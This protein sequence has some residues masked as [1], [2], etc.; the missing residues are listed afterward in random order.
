VAP[1][2][3]FGAKEVRGNVSG[4]LGDKA[5]LSLAA[6]KQQ[7]EGYTVNSVTGNDLDSRDGTFAKAQ[8]LLTPNAN[9]QARVIYSHERNRD[10]D[11]ALGD[12]AAIRQTPF[13]VARDFE[14]F[15]NRD[16]NSGTLNL[17][18]TGQ[19]LS[20]E[21]TTGFVKWN[22]EDETDLDYSP[23]PAATRNNSEEDFQFTQ[24]IRV[25]SP[26]GAPM[27]VGDAIA[28]KWQAGVE[29]FKQNYDQ[30]A[31]NSL[32]AFV[33][34]PQIP[35]PV[36]QT[37]PQAA[38][39]SSGIGVFGRG[40]VTFSEKAD[41]TV[42]LRYHREQS[43]ANLNS[44][45][46]PAIAP[47]SPVVAEDTFSD[48]SPQFALTFR[49]VPEASLYAS[50]SRG[51]KAGGFNPAA[52][53]GSEAYGEEHAWHVEGGLKSTLAAGRVSASAAVFFINWDDLQ[54]NVPNP[55]VPGQFF[56]SNVGGA[57]SRGVEVD[58]T[59]RPNRSLDL[60]ASFGYTNARFADGTMSGGV[61]VA[62]KKIPFTPDYTALVGAQLSR[63]ISSAVTLYGRGEFVMSGA[64]AYDEANTARQDAY[65]LANFRVGGRGKWVFAEAWIRNAF[66]TMYVPIAIPYTGFAPS[67]FIG[68]N[69]RPRTFGVSA[70][71]TF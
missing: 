32:A 6:G 9:W 60:F 11:Y 59:A 39:D 52:L 8:L 31:V 71:V 25:S 23:F 33:L 70:G 4:P 62:D 17:R 50:A 7:R 47:A 20:I 54:L 18:G 28:F 63:A 48:V 21:S 46:T 61:N 51:F 58:L 56:I 66:D 10:G 55:F 19:N 45:F 41:L 22:T 26:Q 1:F 5:A 2:G 16:I 42:G 68:E 15:T 57:R 35:F 34:S 13:V 67:G 38:I 44:F 24:E 49:P 3:D 64:F 53:P 27:P 43:D 69:G 40:T 36:A 12:L 65:S 37:S 14:G 29:Y 30:L